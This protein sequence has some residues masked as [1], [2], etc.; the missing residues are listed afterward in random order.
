MYTTIKKVLAISTFYYTR[1][2]FDHKNLDFFV[3]FLKLISVIELSYSSN[4]IIIS[5]IIGLSLFIK[6]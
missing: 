6:K 4:N 1:K 2:C 3:K 5:M